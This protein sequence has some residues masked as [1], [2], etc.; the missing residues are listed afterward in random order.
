M[1]DEVRTTCVS[2]WLKIVGTRQRSTSHPLTQV[3]LTSF[4]LQ[5]HGP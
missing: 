1:K 5:R 3:V 4:I 2:G